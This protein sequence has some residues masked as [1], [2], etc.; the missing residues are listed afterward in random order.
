MKW[1]DR[2]H[3]KHCKNCKG[4]VK[5]RVSAPDSYK[6]RMNQLQHLDIKGLVA[7]ARLLGLQ[8]CVTG[9][10]KPESIKN[11]IKAERIIE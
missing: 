6:D 4:V 8:E 5:L 2:F 7:R 9:S 1:E 3:S 10:N 11:I